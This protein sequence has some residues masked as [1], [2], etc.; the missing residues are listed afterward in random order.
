MQIASHLKL[1]AAA[2]ALLAAGSA[3]A[4]KWDM[5]LA[6]SAKN[7]H[8]ENAAD[9]AKCVTS[10]TGGK[11]EIVTHPSGSLFKGNEIKRAVQTGQAPIGERL[12]SAHQNENAIFG[13]DSLPFLATSFDD[14]ERLWSVA[15]PTLSKILDS[16]NLVYLY[17][18]AWPPQGLYFKKPVDSVADMKGVKFRS[19]NATTAKMAQLTGMVPTQV[20]A[21]EL[22]QAFATGVVESMISSG[23]TGYDRK[24]WEHTT[25]F[26]EVDA[27]LPRNTV[28]VNKAAWQGSTTQ[29]VR[30]FAIVPRSRRGRTQTCLHLHRLHAQGSRQGRHEGRQGQRQAQVGA[31]CDR[32]HDD[33]GLAQEGRS[34][35]QGH[36]RQVQRQVG[37]RRRARLASPRTRRESS[38]ACSTRFTWA[39]AWRRP[40]SRSRSW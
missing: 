11:L 4:A 2:A 21:A 28:V 18:V 8:S 37:R 13:V 38:A 29:P 16:Q 15:L 30:R 33:R 12:L 31:S 25:H 1:A 5:P 22:S 10:G 39:R 34:G 27:W 3:Q 7:Y 36:R 35:R 17:S 26:Y 32:R 24:L 40:D 23:A 6:Y 19:Y 9:F 14:A 20:E